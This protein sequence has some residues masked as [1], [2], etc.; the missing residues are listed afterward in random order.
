[1][2]VGSLRGALKMFGAYSDHDGIKLYR[3][4]SA[5]L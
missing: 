1:M 3:D 4:T 2:G 5:K